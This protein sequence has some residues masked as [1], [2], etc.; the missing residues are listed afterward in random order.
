MNILF[1]IIK[2]NTNK[3]NKRFIKMSKII[4]IDGKQYDAENFGPEIK[5]Q[6]EM[7]VNADNKISELNRDLALCTTARNT[8]ARIL[9]DLLLKESTDQ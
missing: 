8:Y 6:I 3:S 2:G 9:N 7:I 5:S 4:L 1:N